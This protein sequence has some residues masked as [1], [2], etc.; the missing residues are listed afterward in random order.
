MHENNFIYLSKKKNLIYAL[1]YYSLSS[2][3]SKLHNAILLCIMHKFEFIH[4]QLLKTNK[5]KFFMKKLFLIFF[6]YVFLNF[7]IS[8]NINHY[9][10]HSM[11]Y[12]KCFYP[13]V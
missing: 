2:N 7:L 4:A 11:L 1:R 5:S 6:D 8:L 13:T 9:I 10:L 12:R 3:P